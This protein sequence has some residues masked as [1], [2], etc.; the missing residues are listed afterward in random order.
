MNESN[1]GMYTVKLHSKEIET[2][3]ISA[4]ENKSLR[5]DYC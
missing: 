1:N 4:N 5:L 2:F 3:P